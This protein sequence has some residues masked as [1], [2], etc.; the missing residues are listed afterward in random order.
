MCYKSAI[1]NQQSAIS[2][3]QSAISNQ[4]SAIS[5]QQSAISNQQSAISN[6]QSAISNQQS[7]ISNQQSAI[8]N[9]QSAISNQQ[10]RFWSQNEIKVKSEHSFI[11]KQYSPRVLQSFFLHFGRK[12]R[13]PKVLAVPMKIGIKPEGYNP[14]KRNKG[15]SI[16][17]ALAAAF[18]GGVVLAGTGKMIAVSLHSSKTIQASSAEQSL[19]WSI[20]K[21]LTNTI[22][23]KANLKPSSGGIV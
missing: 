11:Q 10:F 16:I 14:L 2:N 1:S 17:E 18:I 21:V 23:C 13:Q 7:A 15:L 20:S 12:K 5:N 22:P 6:Q 4:Q 19:I 8:S 9:Q 3:Q